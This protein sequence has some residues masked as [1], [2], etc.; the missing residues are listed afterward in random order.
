MECNKDEALRAKE[1]CE[2]KLAEK[3]F[4]GAKKFALKVDKLFN[5]LYDHKPNPRTVYQLI[6][7][8]KP[9][10]T[11]PRPPDTAMFWT[12]MCLSCSTWFLYPKVSLNKKLVCLI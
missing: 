12:F 2:A 4:I 6:N 8:T 7:I 1:I 9:V 3:D 11:I 5:G 10:Q